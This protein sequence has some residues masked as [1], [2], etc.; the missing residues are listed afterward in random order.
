VV[1]TTPE[2]VCEV[3]FL[4]WS[5]DGLVRQASF[6]GLRDDKDPGDIVRESAP[7]QIKGARPAI[8]TADASDSVLG[9][10]LS[11]PDKVLYP[12]M[13]LT[14]R[15]LA[16]FVASVGDRLMGELRDRPVSLVRC[17]EGPGGQ[18]FFQRHG[19]KGMPSGVSAHS[20]GG[21]KGETLVVDSVQG[22]IGL[23]QLG[24]LEVH[25]WGARLDR[26][27]HPDRM[28]LDMDPDEGLPFAAVRAAALEA[29]ARLAAA[30][31][32]SFVKV[33]GG[34]GLHVVV[35]LS[36][37][38]D[39]AEVKAFARA[40][41]EGMAADSPSRYVATMTK[42]KR[43]GKVFIDFFRNDRGSTAVAAWSTRARPGAPVAVPVGWDE[44][45]RLERADVFTV[46]SLRR[47][48]AADRPDPWAGLEQ[49][50]Q[51]LTKRARKAVGLG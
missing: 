30:G 24:V 3:E 8:V 13:G 5:A 39:W 36:R 23:V 14:K 26:P 9:V 18:C 29:H 44:L 48:L 15:G 38:Q 43:K 42:A 40:V 47:R 2:L 45:P 50:N 12:D 51:S 46:D 17:P 20:I 31:L 1:F 16:E 27:D 49:V 37:R 11:S 4:S 19:F 6:Q 7:K 34:K 33:T 25:P 22:L 35:P 10:R 32:E 41:A 28:I 21:T